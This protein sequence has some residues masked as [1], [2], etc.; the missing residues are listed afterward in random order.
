MHGTKILWKEGK[1]RLKKAN[2]ENSAL[3]GEADSKGSRT[4]HR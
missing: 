2:K 3:L 1:I 4:A